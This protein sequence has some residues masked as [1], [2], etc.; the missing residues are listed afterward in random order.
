MMFKSIRS[1][2][3]LSHGLVAMFS[4]LLLGGLV[5]GSLATYYRWREAEYLAD[6]GAAVSSLLVGLILESSD[7]ELVEAQINIFS[8]LT[9]T[10]VKL[11]DTSGLVLADSGSPND[12]TAVAQITLSVEDD[13][14]SQSLSRTI[15]AEEE[16][17][18]YTAEL[19]INDGVQFLR[20]SSS[21]TIA[22]TN[23][24]EIFATPLSLFSEAFELSGS[25][26]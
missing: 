25:F 1:R 15:V 26:G 20:T 24:G 18:D 3:S 21:V 9:Q 6:N 11:L 4:T 17:V 19:L 5:I 8:I 23:P 14:T 7:L 22:R 13:N 12:Q 16:E 10:R 2:L